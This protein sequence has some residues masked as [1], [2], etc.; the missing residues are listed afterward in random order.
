MQKG[1]FNIDYAVNYLET[2]H[3]SSRLCSK[4]DRAVIVGSVSSQI[5]LSQNHFRVEVDAGFDVK[6]NAFSFG[7]VVRDDCGKLVEAEARVIRHP[8]TVLN[9]ELTAILEGLRI[10]QSRNFS[11]AI[12]L[13]DSLMAVDGVM[14]GKEFLG[15]EGIYVNE[16]RGILMDAGSISIQHISRHA[17]LEAH[18]VARH[19]LLFSTNLDWNYSNC[20]SWFS[21]IVNSD[22][23]H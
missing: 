7:V 20:P 4:V 18:R 14:N 6:K 23:Y 15:P 2:F 11:F 3:N 5:I 9:G 22:D 12:I 16:I 1:R 10:C 13:S 19:A 17:N 8:G 21:N